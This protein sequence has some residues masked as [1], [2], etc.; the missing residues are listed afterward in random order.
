MKLVVRGN[1][2]EAEISTKIESQLPIRP[3]DRNA[4]CACASSSFPAKKQRF[5]N[6]ISLLL[7]RLCCELFADLHMLPHK[8]KLKVKKSMC[9]SAAVS[10]PRVVANALQCASSMCS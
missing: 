10:I 8:I 4:T 5:K 7:I 1:E 2:S 3:R 6:A 9:Q